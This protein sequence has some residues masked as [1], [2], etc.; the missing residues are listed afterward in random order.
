MNEQFKIFNLIKTDQKTQKCQVTRIKW[1][2]KVFK[3]SQFYNLDAE[4]LKKIDKD[5]LHL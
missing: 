3:L 1:C 5:I 2:S 4:L